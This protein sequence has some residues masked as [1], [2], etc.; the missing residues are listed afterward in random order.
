[1]LLAHSRL[2]SLI[3]PKEVALSANVMLLLLM[4]YFGVFLWGQSLEAR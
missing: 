3:F 2:P 1:L 4:R